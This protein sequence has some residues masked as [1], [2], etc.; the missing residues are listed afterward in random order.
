MFF[1]LLDIHDDYLFR[2]QRWQTGRHATMMKQTCSVPSRLV[3]AIVTIC[4]CVTLA[5]IATTSHNAIPTHDLKH[6][7]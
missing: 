5:Q 4:Y 7:Q 1:S 6:Y 2:S 3:C